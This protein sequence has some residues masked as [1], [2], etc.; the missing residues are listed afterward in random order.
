MD[1]ALNRVKGSAPHVSP[2]RTL[3]I[4]DDAGD[5]I[6]SYLI[7]NLNEP[8]QL[9]DVSW[10]KPQKYIGIWWE[11]HLGLATWGSGPTHGATTEKAKAYIDF[12]A[13]H[14]IPSVLVEGWNTGWDSNWVG[15][16]RAFNFTQPY[17]DFD[18]QEV[19]RYGAAKGVA[20]VGHHE[21]GGAIENY[22]RQLE[23][24]LAFY[25]KLGVSAV[26]TGYVD[27]GREIERT[28]EHGKTQ[29]EWHYGQ[30]MV[31]HDQKVIEAAARH[32]IMVDAHEPVKDTGLRRTW[33][34][35]MTREGARGQEYNSPL[36]GGNPPDH[37][38]ILPFTRL[39]SGPLDFTPGIFHLEDDGTERANLTPSTLANQ[40]ALYVV[41]YS[42]LQMAA[43]LPRNYAKNLDA[44][45]F[46]KDVPVDWADTKVIHARLGDYVTI[47]RQDRHS[48]DWYLGSITD[49]TGRMLDAP[50]WF[51][52]P[53][54]DYVAEIYR[55]GDGA[56]WKDRPLAIDMTKVLVNS[57]T[58]LSLRLAPGGGQAVRFRL[59]TAEDVGRL[60]RY[61]DGG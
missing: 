33:P 8:N 56:S 23:E 26:K 52:E 16:G 46:I 5:L 32:R 58:V 3:Q 39:L 53:G 18:I 27:F 48:D 17:P 50:L 38:T 40:L 59:A 60:A 44:F 54:R 31:R 29:H 1:G 6:T 42:P 12:A 20:L 14:G 49:E 19:V 30:Y 28:D 47:A 61:A 24:A 41:L 36:G 22:E 15:D 25:E 45:Q 7:L 10:I 37:T 11:M 13:A 55:D 43:D 35:M 57:A 51:L 34:N 21:T 4:G 9:A 2:W